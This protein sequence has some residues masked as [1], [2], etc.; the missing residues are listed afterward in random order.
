E[1]L[2]DRNRKVDHPTY[3]ACFQCGESIEGPFRQQNNRTYHPRCVNDFHFQTQRSLE[4][5][6]DHARTI[7]N[8]DRYLKQKRGK[9]KNGRTKISHRKLV[10]SKIT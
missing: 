7:Q 1:R 6:P 5:L 8:Q 3:V 4:G 2:L 10:D 9:A